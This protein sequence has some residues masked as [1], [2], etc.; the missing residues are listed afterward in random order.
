MWA[1]RPG[2]F[3]TM[4]EGDDELSFQTTQFYSTSDNG[5]IASRSYPRYDI[6]DDGQTHEIAV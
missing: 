6:Q 2:G 1:Y 4:Q 3:A 5:S